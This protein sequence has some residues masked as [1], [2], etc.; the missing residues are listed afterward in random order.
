MWLLCVVYPC[1]Y[2]FIYFSCDSVQRNIFSYNYLTTDM[3]HCAMWTY[4]STELPY[5]I[6]GD[7]AMVAMTDYK[8]DSA[9]YDKL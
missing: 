3:L 2:N 4:P 6:L 9:S 8:Y 7:E 1:Q 5:Y